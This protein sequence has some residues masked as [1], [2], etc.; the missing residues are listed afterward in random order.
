MTQNH[1]GEIMESIGERSGESISLVPCI[2]LSPHPKA[3]RN[4]AL[5]EG[6]ALVPTSLCWGLELL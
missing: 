4:N 1:A 2:V 6:R 5:F 3:G